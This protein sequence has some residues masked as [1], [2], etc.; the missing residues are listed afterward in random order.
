MSGDKNNA[1]ERDE[2][3]TRQYLRDLYA[4]PE[5][6]FIDD[7]ECFDPREI[8]NEYVRGRFARGDIYD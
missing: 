6:E 8:A 4:G 5:E 2:R 1:Y 7:E 3:T